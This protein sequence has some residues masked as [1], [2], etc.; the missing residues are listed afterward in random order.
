MTALDQST[1]GDSSDSRD[2]IVKLSPKK[3]KPVPKVALLV[4]IT[5]HLYQCTSQGK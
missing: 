3:N 5:S 1:L 4:E 2:C